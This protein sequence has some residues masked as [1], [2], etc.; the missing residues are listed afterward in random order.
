MEYV[1]ETVNHY[2][3]LKDRLG[4]GA[5]SCVFLGYNKVTGEK[6]AL[7]VPKRAG[8][9]KATQR[10]TDALLSFR[11]TNIVQLFGIEDEMVSNKTVIV[12]E[13]CSGGSLQTM[14]QEPE[15]MNGLPDILFTLL[16]THLASGLQ[17]LHSKDFVHRDIKPA[18]ILITK[19]VPNI[20]T[21]KIS[22]FGSSR[23]NHSQYD[24]EMCLSLAGTEEYL[25][26]LL[27]KGAFIQKSSH[28]KVNSC[29]DK[30]AL[31]VTL[32]HAASGN[33]PFK[34]YGGAR[35]N[36]QTMFLIISQKP[37]GKICGIQEMENGKIQWS[38]EFPTSCNISS[39]LKSRLVPLMSGL[40]EANN[41]HQW[42]YE[43]FFQEA[44]NLDNAVPIHI[45]NICDC[46][47]LTVY[48][49]KSSRLSM[50]YEMIATE[51]D[52]DR[53]YQTIYFEKTN[54][55]HLSLDTTIKDL[56]VTSRENPLLLIS[57]IDVDIFNS[58]RIQNDIST[59]D[60]A[61]LRNEML[62]KVGRKA[63]CI[64]AYLCNTVEDIHRAKKC[65]QTFRSDLRN[66][67]EIKLKDLQKEFKL[68][69]MIA[70][71][72]LSRSKPCSSQMCSIQ[73]DS[74]LRAR[75]TQNSSMHQP[76]MEITQVTEYIT[77]RIHD[78]SSI[79][80]RNL[81]SKDFTS[82]CTDECIGTLKSYLKT[83][84]DTLSDILKYSAVREKTPLDLVR[85]KNLRDSILNL[86]YKARNHWINHCDCDNK[87]FVNNIQDILRN[88]LHL[89]EKFR[90]L[91][92]NMAE[93][94]DIIDDGSAQPLYRDTCNQ[95]MSISCSED[96][97]SIFKEK[98]QLE[99]DG[100]IN[101]SKESL[102]R[103]MKESD[104]FESLLES[105]TTHDS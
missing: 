65:V 71:E 8:A 93:L 81:K 9:D 32:F 78:V 64:I 76:T 59:L 83:S 58:S 50:L 23:Q 3:S 67:N 56:P 90:E 34:P 25:H 40:L 36:R 2:Y 46:Q 41:A 30:W 100:L 84:K 29:V 24:E 72:R 70:N 92:R 52:I 96:L 62:V 6:R 73:T 75:G 27:Y 13:F 69:K 11:H 31:G 95:K 22:D 74:P 35:R 87:I 57:T 17:E 16:L 21:F 48:L 68:L 85:N 63:A 37:R 103:F 98:T 45:L 105:M 104:D 10:E 97:E 77:E 47:Y 28:V 86:V 5:F 1:G 38:S 102:H 89:N 54:I 42:S 91:S 66:S 43:T 44:Y 101:S 55:E 79:M 12:M 33:V 82:L 80:K 7:K 61:N 14:L 15:Y 20:I 99:T 26:P 94:K 51:T 39:G 53:R 49:N 4:Q 60:N 88:E 19:S 18:N